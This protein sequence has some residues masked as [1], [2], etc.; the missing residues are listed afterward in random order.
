MI[1]IDVYAYSYRQNLDYRNSPWMREAGVDV[2]TRPLEIDAVELDAPKIK[3]GSCELVS[4]T[5]FHC[6]LVSQLTPG[7]MYLRAAVHGT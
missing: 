7:R 5:T 1:S 3:Y 6:W 4:L 2:D